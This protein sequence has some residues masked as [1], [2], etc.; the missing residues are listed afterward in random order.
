M[1]FPK[2]FSAPARTFVDNSRLLY[3]GTEKL[4]Y[5]TAST[6]FEDGQDSSALDMYHIQNISLE[7]NSCT[8][9][10]SNY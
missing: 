7:L 2:Y 5:A 8:I 4:D 1:A 9:K 6:G 10:R 3:T